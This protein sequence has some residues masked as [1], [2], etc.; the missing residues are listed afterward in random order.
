MVIKNKTLHLHNSISNTRANK[1]N[2]LLNFLFNLQY[3]ILNT[4]LHSTA[5]FSTVRPSKTTVFKF[6]TN[7]SWPLNL[8]LYKV[9]TTL[10]RFSPISGNFLFYKFT[11]WNYRFTYSR[12]LMYPAKFE[13]LVQYDVIWLLNVGNFLLWY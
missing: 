3:I 9:T 13:E 10:R 12:M 5:P 8:N 4:H 2:I 6:I 1:L 7:L 11:I